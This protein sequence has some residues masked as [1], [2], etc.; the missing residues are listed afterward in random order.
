[1][2]RPAVVRHSLTIQGHTIAPGSRLLA[3]RSPTGWLVLW[4]GAEIPVP[5][6]ALAPIETKP[7]TVEQRQSARD[8]EYTQVTG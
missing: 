8:E 1:M 3:S 2:I 4:H 5:A 6:D 7:T